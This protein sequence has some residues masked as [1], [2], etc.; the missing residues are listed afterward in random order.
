MSA[1]AQRP[2]AAVG[3]LTGLL[4]HCATPNGMYGEMV[5]QQHPDEFS[6]V[7]EWPGPPPGWEKNNPFQRESTSTSP[8][9]HLQHNRPGGK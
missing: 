6:P 2:A 9:D 3:N 8:P 4:D 7:S 1:V 5:Y